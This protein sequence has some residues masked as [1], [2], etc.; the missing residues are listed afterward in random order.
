M[1]AEGLKLAFGH[2]FAKPQD[3]VVVALVGA[4]QSAEA[5]EEVR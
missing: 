4:A 2:E 3:H 5:V 1:V